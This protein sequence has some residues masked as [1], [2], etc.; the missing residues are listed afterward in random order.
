ML[1]CWVC[2]L[3]LILTPRRALRRRCV[4]WEYSHP[5]V[6]LG[7]MSLARHGLYMRVAQKLAQM[8][9]AYTLPPYQVSGF[10]CVLSTSQCML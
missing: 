7:R 4:W 10:L 2:V 3:L 9:V 1:E 6:E 8:R 5:G